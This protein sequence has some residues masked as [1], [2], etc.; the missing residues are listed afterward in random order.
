MT[1][2]VAIWTTHFIGMLA[3]HL[4]VPVSYDTQLTLLSVVPAI[5]AALLGF[6][7]LCRPEI[8][9]S[10]IA[11]GSVLMGLGISVMHYTGMAALR[12]SPTI[13]YSFSV[14]AFSVVIA[15]LAALGA[16]LIVYSSEKAGW[17]YWLR[18][19]AGGVIMGLA[20]SGMHYTG[21]AA[22]EFPVGSVCLSGVAQI[23]PGVLALLVS[24]GALFLF[25]GGMLA[26]LFDQ[27]M[28]WQKSQ[29]LAQLQVVNS[30][31]EARAR[32]MAEAMPG[33]QRKRSAYPSDT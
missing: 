27:R 21:M 16:L 2:G 1:L 31:L 9:P 13:N 3:F 32:Q 18:Y 29:A 6:Y 8:K 26:T 7:L 25:G 4:P 19:G 12:M 14:V 15:I 17:S 24:M 5:A 33:I 30:S 10:L 23:E 28:V 20:I 11:G 22:A